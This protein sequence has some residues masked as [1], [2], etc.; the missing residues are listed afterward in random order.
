MPLGVF[1][2]IKLFSKIS[3]FFAVKV[4]ELRLTQAEELQLL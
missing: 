3:I 4:M 2:S 1:V